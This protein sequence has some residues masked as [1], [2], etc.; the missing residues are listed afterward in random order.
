[1]TTYVG[2]GVVNPYRSGV[3]GG[4]IPGDAATGHLKRLVADYIDELEPWD[5]PL[6]T[7]I[8]RS[9]RKRTV[10]QLKVETGIKRT[11]PMFVALTGAYTATDALITVGASNAALLQRGMVFR[12]ENERFW[13]TADPNI[14]A[15]T[16]AVAFAQAGTSNANHDSG[17]RVEIIGTATTLD[18][19]TYYN[20]PTIYGDF[21]YNHPQRFQGQITVDEMAA[22]T[23]DWEYDGANK[24]LEMI[25]NEAKYQKIMLNKAIIHGLRQEGTLASGATRP[26][27]MGGI[28]QYL[29]TNVRTITGNAPLSIYD[30]E[31]VTG[32]VWSTYRRMARKLV[33]SYNTKI[34]MNRLVNPYRQGT[35]TDNRVKLTLDEIEVETGNFTMMVDPYMPDGEIWG[36]DFDGFEWLTYQDHDWQVRD[37]KDPTTMADA[38]AVVGAFSMLMPK[39]PL[40]FRITG[41]STNPLDYPLGT[42]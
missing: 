23:P 7:E 12:I 26:S 39:E 30:I 24:L 36:L 34:S 3:T 41:F 13:A 37:T 5:T 21:A 20:S 14:S 17:T 15:G 28:P 27:L 16:I 32:T 19:P 10:N 6:Y 29:T 9:A 25:S 42:F 38:R 18:G 11:R 35:L 1:M 22:V 31:T 8:L 4:S 40:M 2:P 33:M